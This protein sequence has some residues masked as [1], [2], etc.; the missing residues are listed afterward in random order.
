[1]PG[2]GIT[3]AH[4]GMAAH[5]TMAEVE[6]G[7]H[8]LYRMR[9]PSWVVV[10]SDVF[11]STKGLQG[12]GDQYDE[13]VTAAYNNAGFHTQLERRA[14]FCGKGGVEVRMYRFVCGRYPLA[15]LQ[16]GDHVAYA[17]LAGPGWH[18]ERWMHPFLTTARPWTEDWNDDGSMSSAQYVEATKTNAMRHLYEALAMGVAQVPDSHVA[19]EPRASRWLVAIRELKEVFRK[20]GV[21]MRSWQLAER[22][23]KRLHD[24]LGSHARH[25]VSRLQLSSLPASTLET[26]CERYG[27]LDGLC[28]FERARAMR[29]HSVALRLEHAGAKLPHMLDTNAVRARNRWWS[30]LEQAA[31]VTFP[32]D[33][34]WLVVMT[35]STF[36][37]IPHAPHLVAT[38]KEPWMWDAG[39][40]SVI[41]LG[42]ASSV[43]SGLLDAASV[44]DSVVRALQQ[45]DFDDGNFTQGAMSLGSCPYA[46]HGEAFVVLSGPA[47]GTVW[48]VADHDA[49][50]FWPLGLQHK[51]AHGVCVHGA[52]HSH[53]LLDY[54]S[55]LLPRQREVG[56]GVQPRAG[57][58]AGAGAGLG[59]GAGAGASGRDET[60]ASGKAECVDAPALAPVTS[61]ATC[62]HERGGD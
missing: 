42:V 47:V 27:S 34:W 10:I 24:R 11:D 31:G 3:A 12:E 45:D 55:S 43:S 44:D 6:P 46:T 33:L 49:T 7:L 41:E 39:T 50:V 37:R 53:S 62:S 13:A 19:E 30:L 21:G 9:E 60:R 16:H 28:M 48:V 23:E 58:G 54:V 61:P 51:Y 25:L 14:T 56:G 26:L 4:V 59:A 52:E 38:M 15:M 32:R 5:V 20:T 8:H 2:P 36:L 29:L 17:L 35:G 18:R 40:D 22:F 57:A 1:M